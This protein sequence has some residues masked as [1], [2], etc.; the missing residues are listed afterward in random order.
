MVPM[1]R[2]CSGPGCSMLGSSC[3][4]RPTLRPLRTASWAAAIDDGR[5]IV[6]G[7]TT[8]GNSS[9]FRTGRMIVASSG[10][11]GWRWSV[12]APESLLTSDI[13]PSFHK[14]L[15]GELQ[16]ETSIGKFRLAKLETP[17]RKGYLALEFSVGNFETVNET[18]ARDRARA[19]ETHHGDSVGIN[20]HF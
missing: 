15:F 2:K 20:R 6:S 17:P 3:S 5:P 13:D 7:S 10:M 1:R 19:A 12:A 11:T 4:S 8:P 16:H 14:R 18:V 9:M